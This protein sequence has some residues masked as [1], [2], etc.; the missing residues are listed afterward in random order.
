MCFAMSSPSALLLLSSLGPSTVET[1]Q[2]SCRGGTQQAGRPSPQ[3]FL[4]RYLSLL[5]NLIDYY[6]KK[7]SEISKFIKRDMNELRHRGGGSGKG[8]E[9]WAGEDVTVTVMLRHAGKVLT[10][11]ID[12]K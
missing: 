1:P 2:T 5:S 11:K 10:V 8:V 9:G 7:I 12:R 3:L 4:Q 6:F